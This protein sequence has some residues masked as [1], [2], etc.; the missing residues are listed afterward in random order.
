MR[1]CKTHCKLVESIIEESD[2]VCNSTCE[3]IK[4]NKLTS[5][6]KLEEKLSHIKYCREELLRTRKETCLEIDGLLTYKT[7]LIDALSSIRRNALLICQK[8]LIAR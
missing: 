2:R 3:L 6:Y 7:R 4:N 8:C 5:D 1:S